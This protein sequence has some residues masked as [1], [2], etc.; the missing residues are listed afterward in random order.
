MYVCMYVHMYVCMCF[1]C[2]CVCDVIQIVLF[3]LVTSAEGYYV[4]RGTTKLKPVNQK[5]R[6]MYSRT[7]VMCDKLGILQCSL[8]YYY[9]HKGK[10]KEPYSLMCKERDYGN[11]MD[12]KSETNRV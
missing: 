7:T 1:I 9:T 8:Q 11:L 3:G 10:G 6:F 4:M 12:T 5:C 2:V